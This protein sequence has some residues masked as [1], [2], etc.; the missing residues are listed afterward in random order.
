MSLRPAAVL[1]ALAA[2]TLGAVSPAAADVLSLRAE[3]HG[4]AAGGTGV[5]GGAKDHAFFDGARGATYGA[6][7]GAEILFVDAWVEHHQ[8]NDGSLKGTWTQFMTGFDVDIDLAKPAARPGA[9]KPLAKGY[10]ELGVGV[11]FGLGT[12]QQVTLPLDNAQITDKAFLV[13]ARFGAGYNFN[14]VVSL[15]F[16]LP[17]SYGYMFKSGP[18]VVANDD[19]NQ[20]QSLQGALMVNLRFKLKAK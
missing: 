17:V 19:N 8:Y 7:V 2:L 14:R 1:P 6:L 4:G 12:G 16:T 11:G 9:K 15:G 20:Y 13:E 5:A 18:G 3:L 10:A